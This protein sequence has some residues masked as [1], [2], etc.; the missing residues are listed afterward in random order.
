LGSL[1]AGIKAALVPALSAA[2]PA[3]HDMIG[4]LNERIEADEGM[5]PRKCQ[6]FLIV[7]RILEYDKAILQLM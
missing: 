4:F 7:A 3:E 1:D 2:F 5:S 6:Y